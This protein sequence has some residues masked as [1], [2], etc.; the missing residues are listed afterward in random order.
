MLATGCDDGSL[1]IWDLRNFGAGAGGSSNS[2]G[3]G[4][5]GNKSETAANFVANFT[6]HRGPVTSVEWS[7]FDSAMLVTAAEDHTVCMWDLAAGLG[8]NQGLTLVHVSAQTEP[9]LTQNIP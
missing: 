5:G 7:R 6:F 1:R 4:G 3:G 9:F 2:D 8:P